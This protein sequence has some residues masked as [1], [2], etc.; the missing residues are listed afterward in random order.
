MALVAA[1][2]FAFGATAA[3]GASGGAKPRL[4]Q[5]AAARSGSI[6]RAAVTGSGIVQAVRAHAVVVRQL[7]GSR[8]VVPVGPRTSVF[9]NGAPSSLGALRPGF[10]VTFTGRPGRAA[11]SLSATG[12]TAPAAPKPGTVQSVSAT[13]IVVTAQNGGTVTILV[14]PRTRVFLNGSP[15]S[16]GQIAAGDRLA[17]VRGDATGQRAAQALRF[18]R[19]G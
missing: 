18:R 9:L 6:S 19:P 4:V 8:I 17:K 11:Q 7:D 16:I 3:W 2:A 14:A 5:L 1:L 12:S 10:V 13:S 15:V